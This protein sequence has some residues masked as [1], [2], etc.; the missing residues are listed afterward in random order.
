[1]QFSENIV[2]ADLND[3]GFPKGEWDCALALELLEH[4][5]DVPELLA[6]IR[7]VA[8]RLVCIYCCLEDFGDLTERR[9]RDYFND[10]GHADLQEAFIAAGW[11]VKVAKADDKQ[12]LFICE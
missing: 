4:I 12:C 2:F 11:E 8:G 10:F 1:M 9:E 7:P 5:H 6:K 3:G